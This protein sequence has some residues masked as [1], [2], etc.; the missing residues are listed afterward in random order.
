MSK[1]LYPTLPL[2]AVAAAACWVLGGGGGGSRRLYSATEG[3]GVGGGQ[4]ERTKVSERSPAPENPQQAT[5]ST[6]E[7]S[8]CCP[9]GV[10]I[11]VGILTG[12]GMSGAIGIM[13]VVTTTVVLIGL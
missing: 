5:Y 8:G 3:E 12:W 7:G 11:M 9:G 10:A 2:Q 1:T 13:V 6:R 4:H